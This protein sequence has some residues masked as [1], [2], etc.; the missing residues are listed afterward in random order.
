MYL[1]QDASP[2]QMDDVRVLFREYAASL[3]VDL[4]FQ[5]FDRELAGLPG[6]YDPILLVSGLAGCVA[7]HP[8]TPE[9]SEMKR[10][11]VR[12]AH[13]GHGLGRRLAEAIIQAARDRRYRAVRLDTMPHLHEAIALYRSLGFRLIDPYRHN[14]VPGALFME[15]TL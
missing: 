10:M 14:P 7:L 15:L 12:P 4:C 2:D 6:D 1:I 5:D 9:I 8:L 11:Y 13:R 3:G